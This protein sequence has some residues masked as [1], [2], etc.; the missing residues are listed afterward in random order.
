MAEMYTISET[1][2]KNGANTFYYFKYLLENAPKKVSGSMDAQLEE[3][4]P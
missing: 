4:M 3:L 2:L 1:A